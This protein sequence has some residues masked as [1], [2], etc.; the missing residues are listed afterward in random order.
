[1]NKDNI[2][3][4]SDGINFIQLFFTLKWHA[5]AQII[6]KAIIIEDTNKNS[7]CQ[8]PK[9]K[10]VAKEILRAPTKFLKRLESPY[11]LNSKTILS[12]LNTQTIITD[13]ETISC[14]MIKIFSIVFFL[15]IEI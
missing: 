6:K 1:M 9:I 12:Y 7:L 2:K 5:W 8:I 11:C 4:L 3:R 10:M 15:N 14:A 13:I